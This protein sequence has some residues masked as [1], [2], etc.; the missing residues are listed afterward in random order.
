[1]TAD[2]ILLLKASLQTM[3]P[4]LEQAAGSFKNRLFQLNPAL[5]E[6]AGCG[7]ELLQMMGDAVQNIG[8]LDRLAPSARQFGRRY[9]SY[10]I[11]Q[12]DYDA[13]EQAFLWSLG[14]GLGKDFTEEMEAAWGK[15]YWLMT[16]IIRA[17][18]RDGAASLKR[19]AA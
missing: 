3:G 13:V 15:I 14:R 10:H 18:A 11:R 9:A 5:E 16:E 6:I 2:E 4:Q 1:M 8:C 12:Q 7:R 19:A 17:G